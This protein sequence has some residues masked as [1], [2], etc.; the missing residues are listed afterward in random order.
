MFWIA[1][2]GCID[3]DQGAVVV[4]PKRSKSSSA[5][6]D[7]ALSSRRPTRRATGKHDPGLERELSQADELIRQ[8]GGDETDNLMDELG[9]EISGKSKSAIRTAFAEE[10]V[11]EK[12]VTHKA[13]K[14][15]R[16]A[17]ESSPYL[18][19]HAHN[20][21]DW[22][23]WGP[24]AFEKAKKE[25]KLIFLSIGY[26]SCHWCHVMERL[27]F[28]NEPIAK[29]MNDNFVCIKVDREERPDIDDIYMT[30]LSV[31]FRMSG[32]DQNGG[33]P[34]SMFMTA[35]GK[36]VAGGTYFPPDDAE[37]RK[38]FPTVMKIISDLWR[39]DRKSLETN[40]EILVF[41]R[42]AETYFL[43]SLFDVRNN[44]GRR[45]L[46]TKYEKRNFWIIRNH[47]SEISFQF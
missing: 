26:T 23:P 17:K 22:F 33:W 30:A 8:A 21:V 9:T 18:L 4:K 39:D 47:D 44:P 27:V 42:Y 28:S 37:G 12:K 24:E 10:P 19:M 41:N 20:P 31:Y 1:T 16:L 40:A 14:A 6:N 2:A 15:N 35:E 45:I 34:L 25:G 3:A 38:G 43:N 29:Y 11:G 13:G 36:P 7:A 46:E 5:S 32:S